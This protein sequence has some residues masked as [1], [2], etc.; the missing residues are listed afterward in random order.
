MASQ[1]DALPLAAKDMPF[2]GV[3]LTA[4]ADQMSTSIS[5]Q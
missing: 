4:D 5:W 1:G 3:D 2:E